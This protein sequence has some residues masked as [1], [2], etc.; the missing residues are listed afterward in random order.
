MK[1]ER[2]D[3][4]IKEERIINGWGL[5]YNITHPIAISRQRTN[6]K[7]SFSVK[8]CPQCGCVYEMVPNQYKQCSQIHYYEDFPRRGLYH[9]MCFKCTGE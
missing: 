4:S 7:Q 9:Q 8:L 1:S 6:E 2:M 5:T 3:N